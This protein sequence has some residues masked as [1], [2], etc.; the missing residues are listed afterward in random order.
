MKAKL[1]KLKR[2]NW[3]QFIEIEK[4]YQWVMIRS[5]RVGDVGDTAFIP[6]VGEE[7]LLKVR[8]EIDVIL[9]RLGRLNLKGDTPSLDGLEATA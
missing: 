1:G 2:S 9:A 5:G 7:N 4:G 3:V 6:I 8:A